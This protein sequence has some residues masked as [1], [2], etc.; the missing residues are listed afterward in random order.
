MEM[1][2]KEHTTK[3][4]IKTISQKNL[5]FNLKRKKTS[6]TQSGLGT[7]HQKTTTLMMDQMLEMNFCIYDE[8][9]LR[10]QRLTWLTNILV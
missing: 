5:T 4:F 2:M 6:T 7:R 1:P 3:E 10:G 9:P 8:A